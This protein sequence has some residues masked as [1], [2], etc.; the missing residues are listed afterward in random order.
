MKLK[1]KSPVT[2]PA[3]RK[4]FQ[5][6]VSARVLLDFSVAFK[7]K[8][9]REPTASDIVAA[10][11]RPSHPLHAAFRWDDEAIGQS[12]RET[13]ASSMLTALILIDISDR[14]AVT[15]APVYIKVRDKETQEPIHLPRDEV[16]ADPQLAAE[17]LL[18]ERKQIIGHATRYYRD[19]H[20][21]LVA[22]FREILALLNAE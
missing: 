20:G 18:Y 4:G 22:L 8:W 19:L 2:A 13:F 16:L 7:S 10:A 9:G 14:K 5:C 12:F 15:I 17:A 6:N 21:D 1:A 3:W 11:K